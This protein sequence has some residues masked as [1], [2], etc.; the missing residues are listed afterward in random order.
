MGEI[1]RPAPKDA[2]MFVYD[3]ALGKPIGLLKLFLKV[4][5]RGDWQVAHE[6]LT[7]VGGDL[8]AEQWALREQSGGFTGG[9]VGGSSDHEAGT[10]FG[11]N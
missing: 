10:V 4:L 1:N 7:D 8:P 9:G 11:A 6:V 3:Q 2:L 5:E